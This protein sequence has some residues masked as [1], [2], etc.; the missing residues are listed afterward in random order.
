MNARADLLELTPAALMALSNAGFVKRAQKDIAAGALPVLALDDDATVMATFDDGCIARLPVNST[1]RDAHC[2]C[3]ASSM[4]RHRVTLVLAWQARASTTGLQPDQDDAAAAPAVLSAWSPSSFD[5]TALAAT[6]PPGVFD[7]AQR[8]LEARPIASVHPWHPDN[9][10]PMVQLPM[11]SVRFFARGSIAH[12]R[13]DCRQGGHCAHVVLA[14]MAFT[15]AEAGAPLQA[16]R[17]LQLQPGPRQAPAETAPAGA[18]REAMDALLL[19]LWLDGG[20][21]PLVAVIPRIEAVRAAAVA[22]GWCWI[23][24]ALAELLQVL[25]ARHARSTRFE[26]AAL[27]GLVVGTWA[28][29]QSAAFLAAHPAPPLPAAQL[30]GIGVG[31]EIALDR[32]RLV[33]LG[34]AVWRDA[35]E[36]GASVLWA[37]PDT[38]SVTVMARQWEATP[39]AVAGEIAERRVAGH[40]LRQ[41][42]ASQVVTQRATRSAN[43]RIA[44]AAQRQHTGVLPLS[45]HSWDELGLPLRH[46]H[47]DALAA[48]LAVQPPAFTQPRMAAAGVAGGAAAAFHVVQVQDMPLRH[49][50]WDPVTQTL[51]AELGPADGRGVA[52]HLLHP[53]RQ[54]APAAVDALAR[55]LS[56]EFG[57]L[58]A[59]AGNVERRGGALQMRPLA[60]LTERQA[61][62]PQV[63]PAVAPMDLPQMATPA[64]AADP[65]LEQ[66]LDLLALLLQQGL[67][68]QQGGGWE[69][70][71]QQADALQLAGY[72][73]A[74]RQLRLLRPTLAPAQ[75]RTLL[76]RVSVLVLLLQHSRA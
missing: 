13:C 52:L 33:S 29:L 23:D 47:P 10:A 36:E 62:V 22:Q 4:C 55:A 35:D 49:L 41:L 61:V 70:V 26:P 58:R 20:A 44:I 66:A 75:R 34:A 72:R 6:L 12:A 51:H 1:L 42:A 19:A 63:H 76:Q 57:A 5:L 16:P 74:A 32:L 11:C 40:P 73:H 8:L 9:T 2:T 68:H 50:G 30:L 69:R 18:V 48:H 59:V 14:V 60:L 67:R 56:G 7:Q 64:P 25:R 54:A 28:R 17:A 43:G 38:Q 37:D 45:A 21:Q 3:S 15:Q 31:G 71:Q 27:L 39:G 65:A 24:D 46:P 53:H